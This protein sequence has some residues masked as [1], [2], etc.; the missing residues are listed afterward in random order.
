MSSMIFHCFKLCVIKIILS[1]L[2]TECLYQTVQSP[3]MVK[4]EACVLY[5]MD[6]HVMYVMHLEVIHVVLTNICLQME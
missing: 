1:V 5:F 6:K 2:I 4:L 3:D